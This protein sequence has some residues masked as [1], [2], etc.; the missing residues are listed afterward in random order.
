MGHLQNWLNFGHDL[1]IFLILSPFWLNEMSQIQG[2]QAFSWERIGGKAWNLACWCILTNLGTDYI[3]I[4]VCWLSSFIMS[5]PCCQYDWPLVSKW[6]CSSS[7]ISQRFSPERWAAG[8][9]QISSWVIT[10][11]CQLYS[12]ISQILLAYLL[13]YQTWRYYNKFDSMKSFGVRYWCVKIP[14]C[15]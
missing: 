5:A 7:P 2:F 3:W 14:Q 13:L 6:C 10:T 12:N 9:P 15:G 1:L 11:H 8:T 4:M